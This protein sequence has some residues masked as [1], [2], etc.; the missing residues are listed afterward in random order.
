VSL[1]AIW[2][3]TAEAAFALQR[4]VEHNCT[5]EQNSAGQRSGKCPAHQALL[6]QR[7]LDGLVLAAYL[8][9]RLLEAEWRT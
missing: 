6:D 3:G 4:A 8:R 2:H 5:C 7:F 9:E 1:I